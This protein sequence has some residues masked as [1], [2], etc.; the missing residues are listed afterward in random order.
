MDDE[1]SLFDADNGIFNEY[2]EEFEGE[3]LY[4]LSDELDEFGNESGDEIDPPKKQ[5]SPKIKLKLATRKEVVDGKRKAAEEKYISKPSITSHDLIINN[6]FRPK[7]SKKFKSAGLR[8]TLNQYGSSNKATAGSSKFNQPT[9]VIEPKD[10]VS[11]WMTKLS[12]HQLVPSLSQKSIASFSSSQPAPAPSSGPGLVPSQRC[13]PE[14]LD[15]KV[16]V[17]SDPMKASTSK[18]YARNSPE[19][20]PTSSYPSLPPV[21]SQRYLPVR[22]YI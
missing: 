5:N 11:G 22:F 13:V 9:P 2:L 1:G 17:L 12:A 3:A 15:L 19:L 10:A 4:E 8:A 18:K 7:K 21:A 20:M 6:D 16:T 14:K